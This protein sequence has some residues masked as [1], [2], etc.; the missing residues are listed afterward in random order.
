VAATARVL[1]EVEQLLPEV[2]GDGVVAE[3]VVSHRGHL[4]AVGDIWVV[5]EQA[6][7]T[8]QSVVEPALVDQVEHPVAERVEGV[9]I[10][11]RGQDSHV[12]RDMLVV[13][14]GAALE[15]RL[16]QR[17]LE[18]ALLF[19]THRDARVLLLLGQAALLVLLA[20]AARAAVVA[21]DVR[22]EVAS[23]RG[24]G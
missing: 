16:E 21:S 14:A 24:R 7:A 22:H 9:S 23:I 5:H 18:R 3:D 15:D 12:L 1:G 4:E 13:G 19:G 20:A 11:A 8:C 6:L 2:R 17:V 10:D